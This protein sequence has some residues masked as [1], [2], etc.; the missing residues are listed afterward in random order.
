MHAV[1]SK[2]D[3]TSIPD[4]TERTKCTKDLTREWHMSTLSLIVFNMCEN[5]L[6]CFRE[7]ESF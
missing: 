5:C 3:N 1:H 7:K 2:E 4:H 6:W